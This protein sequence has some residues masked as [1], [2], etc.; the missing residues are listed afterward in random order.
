VNEHSAHRH[1]RVTG[2]GPQGGALE[3]LGLEAI[4]GGGQDELAG[5]LLLSGAAAGQSDS[6]VD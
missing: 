6:L 1:P 2:D 4:P 3:A 5:L